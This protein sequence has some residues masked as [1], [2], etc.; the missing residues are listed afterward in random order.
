MSIKLGKETDLTKVL[1]YLEFFDI[2]MSFLLHDNNCTL[3]NEEHLG[4]LLFLFKDV[5]IHTESLIE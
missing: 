4:S 1:I 5:I 2:G 3:S